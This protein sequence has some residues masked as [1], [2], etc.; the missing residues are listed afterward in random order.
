LGETGRVLRILVAAALLLAGCGHHGK[1][2]PVPGP[3]T[4]S[5]VRRVPLPAGAVVAERATA[6][7]ETYRVPGDISF[8]SVERFYAKAMPPGKP[9]QSLRWCSQYSSAAP[10]TI[11]RLWL[12]PGGARLLVVEISSHPDGS[13]VV[14]SEVAVT[15]ATTAICRPAG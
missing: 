4:T 8:A 9:F 10:T 1:S 6:D 2:I 15:P 3:G 12:D 13:L 5:A 14:I 7:K 11:S